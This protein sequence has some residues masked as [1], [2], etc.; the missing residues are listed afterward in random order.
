VTT[1]R[2]KGEPL[3]DEFA[4][5]WSRLFFEAWSSHDPNWLADLATEDVRWEDPFIYPTGVVHG[6]QE[7][8]GWLSSI[9]RSIPD[10]EFRLQ[11]EPLLSLDR[12]RLAALWMGTGRMTGP[13]EPPGFAPTGRRVEMHGLSLH[14]FRG[15]LVSHVLSVTDL[16]AVARQLLAVPARES[17]GEKLGVLLQRLVAWRL[18]RRS[19]A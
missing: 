17:A 6:R 4:R 15:G 1:V 16:S 12:T 13:L 11:G 9:W 8:R 18:R 10:L 7:L 2:V 5:S 19:S 3:T 14:S